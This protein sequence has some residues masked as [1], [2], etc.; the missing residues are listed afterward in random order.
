MVLIICED[1]SDC[2]VYL[3]LGGNNHLMITAYHAKYYANELTRQGGVGHWKKTTNTLV[4][5]VK[6]WKNGRTI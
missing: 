2:R 3:L 4:K 5:H 1:E 6:D